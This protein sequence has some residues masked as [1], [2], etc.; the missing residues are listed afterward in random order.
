MYILGLLMAASMTAAPARQGW[1]TKRLSDGSSVQVRL[2]GDEFYH[3]WQTS[4]GRIAEEQTDGNF[5]IVQ[6][7]EITPDIVRARRAASPLQNGRERRVGVIN[8]A[9]RGLVILAAYQ[10][11]AFQAENTQS[12]MSEMMNKEGY[13]YNG[14]FGSV[15]DYFKAQSNGKYTP[16][17]DVVG[18]ITLPH[19]RA[20]YGENNTSKRGSDKNA[21]QMIVDACQAVDDVVDFTLYDNDK[22]GVIDFVYVIYAGKGEADGG[23]AESVW[24]HNWFVKDGAYITCT[25]DGKMLNNYACSGEIDGYSSGNKRNGIGVLCHEFGHVIGLPD[26]YDTKSS[27]NWEEGLTPNDW[28]VM[29]QGC[30]NNDGK[31]PPNYS[32]F[33]KYFMGWAT[34]KFLAKDEKRYVRMTSHYTDAY[35][36]TG[37]AALV[38]SSKTDTVLY[39]ENRQKENW[40]SY[41]PGHGMIVWQVVYNQYAWNN[42]T[43]NNEAR[44]PRLTL[45]AADGSK[46]IGN[47]VESGVTL[48]EGKSDPFPGTTEVHSFT[49]FEGC[50][51][52]A[53]EETNG[54][55]G[56]LFNGGK[57]ECEFLVMNEHCSVSEEDGILS[58]GETLTLTIT[59]EVGYTLASEDCWAVEMGDTNELLTYGED[60]TYDSSTHAFHIEHVWDDVTIIVQAKEETATGMESIQSTEISVQK[61]LRDGQLLIIHGNRT[62]TIYG[63]QIST[64]NN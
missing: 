58:A 39:I 33:D 34:P 43:P 29:D 46:M 19:E 10:D 40:D 44:K 36:I 37:G 27:T 54:K 4:D 47:I 25:L 41:L 49:A 28:S 64:F 63:Q 51:L 24:P 14:A 17:F 50:A 35:Q 62:Y 8:L 2:V 22:N 30:Y 23:P 26:Y 3:Y 53:I 31:Y 57:S 20:F 45:L 11:V 60:F 15:A 42:N 56:F 38:P 9:P 48:H 16:V 12:T 52:T 32:I 55:V 61:I 1:Q 6:E 59:P 18:P 13:D 5:V 7:S 21:A